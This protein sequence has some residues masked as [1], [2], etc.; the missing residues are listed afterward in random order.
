MT[1]RRAA[2][3]RR[4]AA[5]Q[6]QRLL[7]LAGLSLVGYL[8]LGVRAVQ[9]QALDAEWLSARAQAQHS[10]TI[11]LGPLRGEIR[12]R[13]GTLLAVSATVESVAAS[14]KRTQDERRTAAALARALSLPQARLRERLSSG[15][16]FVWVKRWA[17]PEEAD[18]VRHL[19]LAGVSLHP[20]RKRFYPS[21][22][23]AASYLG[24][25]G[26]DGEG[27][28]GLE[29][30]Y[31]SALRGA[32]TSLPLLRNV[33]G[34]KLIHWKGDAQARAGARLITAL[35]ARLQHFAESALERALARTRA[36][37]AMLVALDPW[38]GDVLALA[39]RPTFDPNRF[40]REDPSAFRAHAFVDPFE[41]GSTLKPF[42]IAIALEAGAVQPSDR[43][44]C[45]QGAWRVGNRVIHDFKPHGELTVRDIV[46]LSSN[47][48][49]SKVAAQLGSARLVAGLRQLGFGE[50]TGSGFPGEAPGTVR[51]LRESQAVER[52]NLAFGQGI[53]VT[54]IQLATAGATLANG[55]YRVWPR[56][57]LRLEG[58]DRTLEWP[59]G[60]GER[61]LSERTSRV[62]K[63]M[64]R[65]AVAHGTGTA[66]ALPRHDV[67]GKT[68]TAQKVVN[69]SYSTDRFVASFLGFV[70]V[71]NPRL[72]VVVVIDEPEGRHTGGLVAAPVFRE[73][74]AF[75][76][77]QLSLTDEGAA[78]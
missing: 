47:I 15:R 54:T 39:E 3:K 8:A 11:R 52:A 7:I 57:V 62:V 30:A 66:A 25:A 31:D 41:P 73:L 32:S 19:K 14:P 50:S 63:E 24:F 13:H 48:G 46:R 27:L 78:L 29:L 55:G 67:A 60:L 26:R 40:W 12:D 45:E 42:G 20:E 74:A 43:F 68:G 36:K 33:H 10:A 37:H 4:T 23:L 71:E 5:V 16:S 51:A 28:A 18:R 2:Q 72:V 49:A 38:T 58:A 44:D 22:R 59:S 65:D 61:V 70:P 69:G 34:R 6:R 21:R 77:E 53:T 76:V 17:T 64:L 9:L 56:L 1:R 75:A 35:D